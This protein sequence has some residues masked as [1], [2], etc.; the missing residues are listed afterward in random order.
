VEYCLR[1]GPTGL[2]PAPGE[3][4]DILVDRSARRAVAG[5]LRADGW[6]TLR[7]PGHWGH[8]FWLAVD[9]ADHWV[10]LDVVWR[11]RYGS[12]GESTRGW[13]ASRVAVDGV[14]VADES[15]ERRHR[16]QRAAGRRERAGLLERLAR[17]LPPAPRRSGPVL[18]VLGPDGAGKG[19]VI[20]GLVTS[21]PVGVST[22]YLGI[23]RAR[24]TATEGLGTTDRTGPAGHGSAAADS[25]SLPTGG[26]RLLRPR[27]IAFLTRKWLRTLP[28][29]ARAYRAAWKGHVVLLDRHPVDALAVRPRRTVWGGRFERLLATRLTPRPD[30]FLVLDAPGAVLFARK[31]EHTPEVLESWRAG[32]R[33]LPG[34]GVHVLDV[35]R[36]REAVAAQARRLA[37]VELARRRGWRSEP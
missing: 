31:G 23:R 30:A 4:V 5:V 37:W 12:D 24:P 10:K 33:A 7:A 14:W 19:T 29:F 17:Q 28:V 8:Q 22:Q 1:N 13:L 9:A 6:R 27:E 26:Q 15:H 21:L 18:A 16:E 20:E 2:A 34:A 11:I 3:D 25:A 32:Y 36:S 35:T